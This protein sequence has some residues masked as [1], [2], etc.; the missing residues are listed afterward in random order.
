MNDPRVFKL[1][2]LQGMQTIRLDE[3]SVDYDWKGQTSDFHG[4]LPYENLRLKMRVARKNKT[5]SHVAVLVGAVIAMVILILPDRMSHYGLVAG[6]VLLF[7][8]ALYAV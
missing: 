4:T 3:D 6:G 5:F 2:L 1:P 7:N 8:L